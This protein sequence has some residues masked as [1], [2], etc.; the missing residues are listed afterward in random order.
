MNNRCPY[1]GC[2][3]DYLEVVKEE[4]TWNG[5]SWQHD[6]KAIATIRCP[7]CGDELEA[8]DLGILG[9]EKAVSEL[10]GVPNETKTS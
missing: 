4:I 2:E 1:C 8:I 10:K 9:C 6:G 7:E 5:E 3:M